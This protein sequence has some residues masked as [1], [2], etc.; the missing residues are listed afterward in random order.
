MKRNE[1]SASQ[2][3]GIK[4]YELALLLR[5]NRSQIAMF[6]AG[7]RDLPSAASILLMQILA[8]VETAKK[9][10]K[11]IPD[12]SASTE[13]QKQLEQLLEENTFQ[14]MKL[15]RKI[16]VVAKKHEVQRNTVV[17]ANFLKQSEEVMLN[18]SLREYVIIKGAE[19]KAAT[20]AKAMVK[21]QIKQE[22]LVNEQKWL[23]LQLQVQA[24]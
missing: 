20:N 1:F 24:K 10:A 5:V 2:S 6:E 3:L 7:K 18:N 11:S 13:K 4:Q 9:S 17:F 12:A 8:Q 15:R 22:L 14:Q 23:E 16:A 21:L 19:S